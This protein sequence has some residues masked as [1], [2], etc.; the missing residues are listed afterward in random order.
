MPY[1]GKFMI[2]EPKRPALV[3]LAPFILFTGIMYA[4][5]IF[6]AWQ[7]GMCPGHAPD[8]PPRAC[9]PV[10]YALYHF[11]TPFGIL[12]LFFFFMMWS[13]TI[14]PTY[15][16]VLGAQS[17]FLNGKRFLG[18]LVVFFGV[19]LSAWLAWF[20]IGMYH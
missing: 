16:A 9:T 15:V 17:L 14:T 18:L 3:Y 10:E 13:I 1:D 2:P 8:I 19:L 11:F 6:E 4:K 12:G 7:T 5:G 20:F